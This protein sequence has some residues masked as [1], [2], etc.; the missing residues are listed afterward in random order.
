MP[1]GLCNA[2]VTFEWLVHT[3]DFNRAQ[4]NLQK[5]FE[6]IRRAGLRLNPVLRPQ[7]SRV[8]LCPYVCLF[9]VFVGGS[10]FHRF[11]KDGF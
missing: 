9:V 1:F 4:G 8:F 2:P 6:A 3:S 10:L 7:C 11:G 5:V